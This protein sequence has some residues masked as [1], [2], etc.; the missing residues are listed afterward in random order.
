MDY[1]N[2]IT[3]D[4]EWVE[5][6]QTAERLFIIQPLLRCEILKNIER[7]EN[8]LQAEIDSIED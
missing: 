5:K 6:Y 3:N 8:L 7:A 2:L 4:S 1:A